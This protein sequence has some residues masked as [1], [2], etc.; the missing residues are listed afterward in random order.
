MLQ[1]LKK[2]L[3]TIFSQMH[4]NF[5]PKDFDRVISFVESQPNKIPLA[6]EFRHTNWYNDKAIVEDLNQL[7]EANNIS[8]VMFIQ[9]EDVI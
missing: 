6:I 7:L 4:S 9:Q 5:A 3:G 1:I 2:K 8:N